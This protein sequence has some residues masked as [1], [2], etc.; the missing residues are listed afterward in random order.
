[1]NRRT[2]YNNMSAV[3]I[4][5]RHARPK[6][7]NV[8]RKKRCKYS[9]RQPR[10]QTYSVNHPSAKGHEIRQT[11]HAVQHPE[12]LG[13]LLVLLALPLPLIFQ[14]ISVEHHGRGFRLEVDEIEERGGECDR[15]RNLGRFAE[16]VGH[17][18][19][20]EDL[21]RKIRS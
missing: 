9:Y 4:R 18:D 2:V 5:D 1:M 13:L 14:P 17:G 21:S 7:I 15:Q 10:G 11:A 12:G 3:G 6:E 19:E 20:G 8:C 16:Y